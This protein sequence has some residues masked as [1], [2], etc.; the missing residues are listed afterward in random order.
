MTICF[1]PFPTA[2][3]TRYGQLTTAVVQ[4]QSNNGLQHRRSPWR[5]AAG[6]QPN[7]RG[8]LT[9][10]AKP[11]RAHRSS[12]ATAARIAWHQSRY[13]ARQ[14]Q[15]RHSEQQRHQPDP[16]VADRI[17]HR[18]PRLGARARQEG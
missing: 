2:I 4:K 6:G 9:H 13:L 10:A 17:G 8:D 16:A 14:L 5:T 15:D 11:G 1:V 18:V 3:L 12:S 7:E